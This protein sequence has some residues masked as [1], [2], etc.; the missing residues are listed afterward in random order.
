ME[1][2][3]EVSP[4]SEGS[5]SIP[6]MVPMEAKCE[7]ESVSTPDIWADLNDISID[8]KASLQKM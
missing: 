4:E 7:V 2:Y 1:T 8:E 6:D 3:L 5:L